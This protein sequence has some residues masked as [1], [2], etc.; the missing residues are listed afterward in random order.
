MW[1]QNGG[2]IWKADINQYPY[3]DN[4]CIAFAV[5]YTVG[6]EVFTCKNIRPLNSRVAIFLSLWHTGSTCSVID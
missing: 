5:S 2:Y 6:R 1:R 3:L 4:P